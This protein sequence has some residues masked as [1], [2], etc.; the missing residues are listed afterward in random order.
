MTFKYRYRKQILIGVIILILLGSGVGCYFYFREDKEEVIEEKNIIKKETTNKKENEVLL[1]VDIK[2][3]VN[4]PGIYS[5]TENSRVV[6]VIEKAGGLTENADTSVIN[7]SKKISDEMVII[8]YSREEVLDFEKTKEK[9]QIV[10]EKCEQKDEN[11]LINNACITKTTTNNSKVSINTASKEELM[12]L[13]GIGEKKAI[14]IISYREQN[15]P[16]N[17]VEDLL[18]IPGIGENLLATIKE[19]ITL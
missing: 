9:E 17:S 6:D 13:S 3:Q 16:F 2:G 18:N 1:Q 12:T 14:D 10:Q 15:G 11:S 4:N 8:I 19:D 5:L 7:L